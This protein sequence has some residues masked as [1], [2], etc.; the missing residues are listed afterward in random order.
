VIGV[1]PSLLLNF[2]DQNWGTEVVQQIKSDTGLP[3]DFVFHM[4]IYYDDE[5]WRTLWNNTVKTVHMDSDTLEWEFGYYSGEAL[6]T[7]FSGFM[8]G[9]TSARQMIVRQPRIHNSL[10][11]SIADPE[12]RKS[13]N[14]K[15]YLEEMP[16][17]TIMHY[18]SPNRMCVFYKSLAYYVAEAFNED[19][20]IEEHAC[21]KH[22]AEECTMHIHYLGSHAS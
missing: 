7:Q 19:I 6:T 12:H 3:A 17:T 5:Q 22:G 2:V 8:S 10:S 20:E 11:M 13:V 14:E 9:I 18:A 1:I 16:D 21:M 4:H 15:F